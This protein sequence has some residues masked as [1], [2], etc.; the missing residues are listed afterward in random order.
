[1]AYY[2]CPASLIL[3]PSSPAVFQLR[4]SGDK[5]ALVCYLILLFSFAVM[6]V[7]AGGAVLSTLFYGAGFVVWLYCHYSPGYSAMSALNMVWAMLAMFC[8][9]IP[10]PV[11]FWRR[12]CTF[13]V[14]YHVFFIVCWRYALCCFPRWRYP[15]LR[16]Y[17]GTA[18]LTCWRY[19]AAWCYGGAFA[20]IGMANACACYVHCT[21][22]WC[23]W[24]PLRSCCWYLR[25]GCC[26]LAA[27]VPLSRCCVFACCFRCFCTFL[28]LLH[29]CARGLFCNTYLY[30]LTPASMCCCK[31]CVL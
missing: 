14:C 25:G 11:S 8:A 5:N 13:V 23:L 21:C 4:P 7:I 1:M 15:L 30:L 24:F 2:L 17:R 28:S 9:G 20:N 10:L 26:L 19:S 16:V 3:W 29:Y 6:Y 22:A 31:H 18:I 12:V 27:A